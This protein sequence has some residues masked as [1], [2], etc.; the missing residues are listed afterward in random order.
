MPLSSVR[1]AAILDQEF[2]TGTVYL[3]LYTSNPTG[4]DTGTEVSGGGYARQPIEF[5]APA[6]EGGKQTIKNAA[7]IRFPVATSD[8]GT[9]THIGIRTAATGGD[10]I[11]YAALTNPRTI[12]AGDRFVIDLN[13]GV[14]RLA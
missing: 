5:S 13:N 2:R 7:E 12:L 4:A 8:W 3:A 1:A 11:A 14:V 10:L 6:D 9:V